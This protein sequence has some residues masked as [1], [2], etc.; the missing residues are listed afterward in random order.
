MTRLPRR[1]RDRLDLARN[2][3]VDD[4][5]KWTDEDIQAIDL[6]AQKAQIGRVLLEAVEAGI[7]WIVDVRDGEPVFMGRHDRSSDVRPER[8]EEPN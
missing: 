2:R 1:R 4:E 3:S 7:L 8:P 5:R 6:W